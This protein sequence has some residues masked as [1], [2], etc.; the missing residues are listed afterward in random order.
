[1]VKDEQSGRYRIS[2]KAF[3][4]STVDGA[5]SGDL[6]QILIGDGLS[7]IAMYPA[8]GDAVGAASI[9]I[10]DIR[11]V[12]ASVEHDPVWKNWYHGSVF[13][14]KP[15]RVKNSLQRVAVEI[16][17]IDQIEAARLWNSAQG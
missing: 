2:S 15:K 5:L 1:V 9:S 4:P 3:G 16:I 14:T 17:A 8:V 12:G 7:P 10:G 11:N 6:E 13:G